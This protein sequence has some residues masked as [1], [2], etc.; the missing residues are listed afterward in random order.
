[1]TIKISR[2]QNTPAFK[3]G[4]LNHFLNLKVM[5]FANANLP[6]QLFVNNYGNTGRTYQALD[7]VRAVS[8]ANDRVQ[9][10]PD[11]FL[12]N[13]GKLRQ[14]KMTYWP[15]LCDVDGDCNANICDPGVVVEPK[16]MMFDID[17]CTASQVFRVNKNDVRLLDNNQW[18]YSAIGRAIVTSML[19]TL[20]RQ[21]AIDWVT[22]LHTLAG[23]HPDGNETHRISVTDPTSGIV[24]PIG[25]FDIEREYQDSG[26]SSPYILGGAEVWNWLKM[27]GIGGLNFSGQQINKL[28]VSNVWYDDGL[29]E[30][31]ANDAANGGWIL[32]IAP[33]VFKYVY[34]LENAG[35]FRTTMASIDDMNMLFQRGTETVLNGTLIDPVTG[36]PWDL[37][38][39]YSPCGKFWN[40]QLR[41]R[42]N[43]FVLPDVACNNQG[44]NGIMEY[45][46]CPLVIAP[47]PTG[48]SP[49]SPVP[50][51]TFA[52]TPGDVTFTVYSSNIGG[53]ETQL[54]TPVVIGT[55]AQLAAYM[56]GAS[57]IAF[58]VNGST[59]EYDGFS[60]ISGSFITSQGTI[61]TSFA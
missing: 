56:S 48:D 58:R 18:D 4:E 26:F 30:Q 54:T 24:N 39:Y 12:F 42:W 27:V 40:F 21:L 45:R 17:Q 33:E 14:V 10:N 25:R 43:F 61:N 9:L 2:R 31:V 51:D 22:F 50:V 55:I 37:D 35:I 15:I 3:F 57:Q 11:T 46:T 44:V 28:D 16:Q 53:V 19:P 29:L 8:A 38:I 52:W 32:A 41:H 59:I 60:A 36:I 47:C 49:A 34:Y 7:Y 6:I 5:S 1:M 13:P 20:R 23:V